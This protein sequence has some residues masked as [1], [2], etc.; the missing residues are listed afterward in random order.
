MIV[1]LATS[2]KRILSIALF[3]IAASAGQT[4][5]AQDNYERPVAIIPLGQM[6]AGQ[7]LPFR[8]NSYLPDQIRTV[9]R[10][11]NSWID[12][13]KRMHSVD[14]S[15][16]DPNLP[17]APEI[18]FSREMLIV[19]GMGNQPSSGFAVF[20][21]AAYERGPALIA[22]VRSVSPGRNCGVAT[23]ITS[24]VDIVRVTRTGLPVTFR[25]TSILS[26][27]PR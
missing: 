15:H 10:D 4:L 12:L 3:V 7:R 8:P 13:W 27:C 19:A 2:M 5:A 14:P 17:P 22:V 18:D 1:I 9:V 16:P 6:I 26:Q 25:E 24:P 20:I 11:R 21:D 23:V